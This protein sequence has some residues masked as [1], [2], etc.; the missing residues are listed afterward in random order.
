MHSQC[1]FPWRPQDEYRAYLDKL[2]NVSAICR[3]NVDEEVYLLKHL[4]SGAEFE[5]LEQES[6][7]NELDAAPKHLDTPL[8]N[9]LTFLTA[10]IEG[11]D[12]YRDESRGLAAENN[13]RDAVPLLTRTLSGRKQ[14]HLSKPVQRGGKN[15]WSEA[16]SAV[17]RFYAD[18]SFNSRTWDSQI[19]YMRPDAS[20]TMLGAGIKTLNGVWKDTITGLGRKLGFFFLSDLLTRQV[21]ICLTDPGVNSAPSLAKLFARLLLLKSTAWGV[22]PADLQVHRSYR[23]R[24][25]VPFVCLALLERLPMSVAKAA[26]K[27]PFSSYRQDFINGCSVSNKEV[28]LTPAGLYLEQ[29]LQFTQQFVRDP[30]RNN[31]PAYAIHVENTFD[32]IVVPALST[33]LTAPTASNFAC[34]QR[35]LT[36]FSHED[37][38]LGDEDCRCF[39]EQLLGAQLSAKYVTLVRATESEYVSSDAPFDVSQHVDAQTHVAKALLNRMSNDVKVY[40]TQINEGAVPKMACLLDDTLA[41]FTQLHVADSAVL[42]HDITLTGSI[43]DAIGVLTS[44]VS[45]LET[46]AATDHQQIPASIHALLTLAN[47]VNFDDDAAADGDE[48]MADGGANTSLARMQFLLRRYSE[49]RSTLTLDYL[50]ACLL[51]T[52]MQDDIH[53]VNPFLPPGSDQRII[54]LIQAL[55][56][57]VSRL[58]HAFRTIALA[59]ELIAMLRG[60]TKLSRTGAEGESEREVAHKALVFKSSAL[61][62]ALVTKRFCFGKD[63]FVSNSSAADDS[64]LFEPRFLL[65]EYLFNIL[66]RKQQ[67]RLINTFLSSK[68]SVQQMMSV[69]QCNHT[70]MYL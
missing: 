12:A 51:S 17:D 56:L 48:V 41:R 47:E 70:L 39:S 2:N 67:V 14:V 19:E 57:R 1:P 44:L 60:V 43:N 62:T 34:N 4:R 7:E 54:D 32:R 5:D 26:P 53:A 61:A 10:M 65:F 24:S 20:A 22:R 59:V 29:L 38:S 25:W 21:E 36:P 15:L 42:H 9:R 11:E 49:L 68:S 31:D 37:V 16:E 27:L 30:K 28:E 69:Q 55:M 58:G 33:L 3:L 52:H 35:Q 66:L 13:A 8:A 64:L 6:E 63:A 23:E 18:F 45:E 40:A 46:I 50:C